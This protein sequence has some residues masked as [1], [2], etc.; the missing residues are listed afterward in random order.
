MI[1][2]YEHDEQ[3]VHERYKYKL[4]LKQHYDTG[5]NYLCVTKKENFVK[6]KGSGISWK[7]L[8]EKY[9]DSEILTYILFVSND[10]E[11]FNEMC[12]YYS[13]L[14]ELPK[15]WAFANLIAEEG[16]PTGST[17]LESWWNEASNEQKQLA[18]DKAKTTHRETINQREDLR[19][20]TAMVE[21]LRKYNEKHGVTHHMQIPEIVQRCKESRVATVQERYG[22]DCILSHPPI[23]ESNT[24]RR[25]AVMM[26]R[27]GVENFLQKPGEGRSVANK[28]N[29]TILE[30]YGVD[31]IS[32]SPEH[33]QKIKE[34]IKR[35]YD[36]KP[37]VDCR[38]GCGYS[39][40]Q[41]T[42]HEKLCKNNP[43]PG[44]RPVFTC[45]HCGKTSNSNANIIR[46]HNDNCKHKVVI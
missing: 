11:Q 6:Y 42:T 39:A 45:A 20:R 7:R 38:F 18:R 12:A 4:M 41:T 29:A 19:N 3:V 8:I 1:R 15:H 17:N 16:Y 24:I 43:N 31:N 9:P 23:I 27:Y 44:P 37:Y 2:V 40:K 36:N 21:G 33:K 26:E 10:V 32:Q 25:K 13:N 35:A 30:R 28:R 22:V 5:V 34:G 46:W 14:F